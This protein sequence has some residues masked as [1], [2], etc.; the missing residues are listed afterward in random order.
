MSAGT[1]EGGDY[2]HGTGDVL[3]QRLG[4]SRHALFVLELRLVLEVRKL[5]TGAAGLEVALEDIPVC[6]VL[7]PVHLVHEHIRIQVLHQRATVV[8]RVSQQHAQGVSTH[9]FLV[10]AL[11]SCHG[12]CAFDRL[13]CLGLDHGDEERGVG[14]VRVELGDHVIGVEDDGDEDVHQH[15]N[16]QQRADPEKDLGVCVQHSQSVNGKRSK[17]G[18]G[19]GRGQRGSASW[20]SSKSKSPTIIRMSVLSEAPTVE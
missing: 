18:V 13:Q 5:D 11:S 20:I 8:I 3:H 7:Y 16:Q 17:A 12:G 2:V 15:E 9:L 19:V 6:L 14:G 1:H 10:R 4:V